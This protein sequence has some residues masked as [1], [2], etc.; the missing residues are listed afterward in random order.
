MENEFYP[1]VK[2]ESLHRQRN[3]HITYKLLVDGQVTIPSSTVTAP[4]IERQGSEA[5][6]ETV[7][8][9]SRERF[10]RRRQQVE[11]KINRRL[12]W[13]PNEKDSDKRSPD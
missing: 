9:V 10:A 3:Y 11:E 13:L 12:S 7:V 1:Y 6:A 8:R 2:S 5:D 4:P